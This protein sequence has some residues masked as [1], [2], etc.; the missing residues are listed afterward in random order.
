MAIGI[1]EGDDPEFDKLLYSLGSVSKHCP[2]SMI[3]AIMTWRKARSDSSDL[4]KFTE[5]QY[6]YFVILATNNKTKFYIENN[7]Y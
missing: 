5:M 2:K 3:D 6:I 1:R 4:M 7:F